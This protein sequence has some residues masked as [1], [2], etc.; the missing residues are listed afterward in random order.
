LIR[1]EQDRQ[2]AAQPKSGEDPNG[3]PA[4]VS[5]HDDFHPAIRRRGAKSEF[6]MNE[7]QAYRVMVTAH[8]RGSCWSRYPR[9][10]PKSNA[11]RGTEAGRRQGL[12]A[13]VHHR[14]EE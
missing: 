1:D 13:A 9:T 6:R 7:D 14:A 2:Q 11:T 10:S 12:S 3:A 5:G 8:R 4:Q